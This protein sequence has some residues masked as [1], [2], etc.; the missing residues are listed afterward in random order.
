[1]G[2]VSQNIDSPTNPVRFNTPVDW[3]PNQPFASYFI[4]EIN[5]ILP[6]GEF[7]FCR[8]YNK[9]LPRIIDEKL[10]QD[11][12][13]FIR[14]EAMHANAHTSANKEYLSARNID[15]QRN[16]DIMNY[17]FTT[18]LADKPF[19]KEVPQFL[20]EQWDLFR[21]GVIATVEH[22]TCVLGKYALYNKRWEELGADPEMVDL[23]KWH[24]S[25]EIEH[26]TVAFDLYRHLGGGYIPRYYLS[27]AV[28]VLV[29][30][31]WVDG[32]AHIMKQ[33]PRFAD[34][35]KSRFFPA[36]VALE[37]YKISRKDNQVLPNPIWLI[38]QQIDYL[39]PW[40]DPVKEGSTEDA[41]SYL[42]QSPAA[43]RAE[44]QA[45]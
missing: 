20:Q 18:A 12:Q 28:I 40:Y 38:A 3:I 13:A 1:M 37:W 45:A 19:D 5:N 41:V 16:L 14:Q 44:L 8:L 35:A 30:G 6:A 24:G 34:A 33:D 36:W 17:L 4:N 43:K 21:L 11:V 29:L 7:W 10:K 42:S 22:M 39:M 25:E 9:V 15:I 31:L 2:I 26:R 32:A 23:V 27:L